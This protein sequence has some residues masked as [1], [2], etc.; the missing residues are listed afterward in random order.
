M[1][2][3]DRFKS[4]KRATAFAEM[5]RRRHIIWAEVYDNQRETDEVDPFPFELTPPIVLVGR[6]NQKNRT[7]SPPLPWKPSI[8]E[9]DIIK[10]VK[11]FH[12]RFAGT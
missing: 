11:K 7:Y 5:V 4:K 12:G 1:L 6:A 8:G 2:I 3:F 9:D 10:L